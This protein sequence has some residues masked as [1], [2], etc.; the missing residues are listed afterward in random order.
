MKSS[1]CLY[2]VDVQFVNVVVFSS[3]PPVVLAGAGCS[4][5]IGRFTYLPEYPA[6]TV[7]FCERTSA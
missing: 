5:L 3:P 4:V 1:L 2:D 6:A 7:F